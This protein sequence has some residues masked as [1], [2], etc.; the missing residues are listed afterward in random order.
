MA[1][2]PATSR[3]P[4]GTSSRW[5]RTGTTLREADPGEDRIY[6]GKTGRIRLSVWHIDAAGDALDVPTNDFTVVHQLDRSEVSF[7]EC[8]AD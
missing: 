8:L 7:R 4:L 6:R 1:V 5:M 2:N 3:T